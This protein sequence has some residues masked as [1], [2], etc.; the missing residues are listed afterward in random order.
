MKK[1]HFYFSLLIPVLLFV[2]ACGFTPMYAKG[3]GQTTT[4]TQQLASIEIAN[5]PDRSGQMLR[6]NLV[7]RLTPRGVIS[8]PKY[9]LDFVQMKES[10]RDLDITVRSDTTREQMKLSGTLTLTDLDTGEIVLTKP[11]SVRGSY[12]ILESEYTSRVSRQ[13][14]RQDLL[15]KLSLQIERAVTLYLSNL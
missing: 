13:D 7:D 10:V 3:G 15:E 8:A 12:N 4:T 1:A 5:I 14:L 2:S 11:L 9:K 6:N